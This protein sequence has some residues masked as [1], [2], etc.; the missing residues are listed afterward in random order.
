M[1]KSAVYS[2][3]VSNPD[4]S[5]AGEFAWSQAN[6]MDIVDTTTISDN[7]ITAY[8]N[9]ADDSDVTTNIDTATNCMTGM[10][11]DTIGILVMIANTDTIKAN[12]RW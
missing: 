6:A 8:T 1:V 2:R 9:T 11:T 5:W 4:N 10:T 7:T 12:I 3:R